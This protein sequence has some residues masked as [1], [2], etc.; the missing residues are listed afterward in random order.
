MGQD[1]RICS[2]ILEVKWLLSKIS[3]RRFKEL[4]GRRVRISKYERNRLHTAKN[5]STYQGERVSEVANPCTVNN[6][7]NS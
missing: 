5:L 2:L 1:R 4:T 7:V 3:L 6:E